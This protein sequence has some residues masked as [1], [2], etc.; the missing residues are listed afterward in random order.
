M[1]KSGIFHHIKRL[2]NR[3]CP[4]LYNN[5]VL[6]TLPLWL[7]QP[8]LLLMSR[9]TVKTIPLYNTG[10]QE[11]CWAD[12][13]GHINVSPIYIHVQFVQAAQGDEGKGRV[14]ARSRE[15]GR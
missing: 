2:K 10:G 5:S 3:K 6:L 14:E 1:L 12:I 4:A 13:G 15:K 8:S 11:G 9:P 7:R